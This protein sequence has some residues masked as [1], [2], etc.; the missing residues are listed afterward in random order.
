MDCLFSRVST[1]YFAWGS[2]YRGGFR[3]KRETKNLSIDYIICA[4]NTKPFAHSNGLLE[5]NF[6]S[7]WKP[8]C[9][10]AKFIIIFSYC[11]QDVLECELVLIYTACVL[12]KVCRKLSDGV[13]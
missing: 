3:L 11:I 4:I 6:P 10:E 1:T 2:P 12:I 5:E 9:L 13:N 7:K 8:C